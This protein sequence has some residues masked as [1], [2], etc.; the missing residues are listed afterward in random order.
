VDK[1]FARELLAKTMKL[2]EVRTDLRPAM[3][4]PVNHLAD[5]IVQLVGSWRTPIARHYDARW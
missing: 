1:P 5:R 3:V 4:G 2:I